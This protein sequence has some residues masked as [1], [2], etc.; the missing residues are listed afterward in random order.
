MQGLLQTDEHLDRPLGVAS[1]A[2]RAAD[3]VDDGLSITK[4]AQS[5]GLSTKRDFPTV[6]LLLERAKK[7][8]ANSLSG[9]DETDKA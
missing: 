6:P 1:A 4:A 8:K 9:N 7:V 2:P 3:E 5:I